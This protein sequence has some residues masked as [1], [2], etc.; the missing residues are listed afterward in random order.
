MATVKQ[1]AFRF[2]SEDL[3]IVDAVQHKLGIVNR[4]D[5]LRMAIRALAEAQGVNPE[6][7]PKAKAKR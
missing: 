6:R 3:A 7:L 1:T 4:T 2:T 5:V